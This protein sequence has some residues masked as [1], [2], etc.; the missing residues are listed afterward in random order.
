VIIPNKKKMA[1]VIVSRM[2]GEGKDLPPPS[3][4][5]MAG[6]DLAALAEDLISAV[7]SKDAGA[8]ADAFRAMFF[9]LDS[10]PEDVGED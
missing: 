1:S 3:A 5:P 7:E 2:T 10:E 6:D 8:V 4:E 9:A